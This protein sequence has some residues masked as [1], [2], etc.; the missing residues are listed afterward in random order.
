MDA[1][2]AQ[3]VDFALRSEYE[4]LGEAT[5]HEC[6][7]RLIDTFA[8]AFGAYDQPLNPTPPAQAPR[9]FA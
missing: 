5:I 7:R 4:L 2:T 1:T 8:A 3:L 6:K 9:G